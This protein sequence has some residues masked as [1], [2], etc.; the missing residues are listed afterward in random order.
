MASSPEVEYVHCF[1]A[2]MLWLCRTWDQGAGGGTGGQ[3]W[4][5]ESLG[6]GP[7]AASKLS[8]GHSG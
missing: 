7:K 6:S 5:P 3:V 2:N 4:L 8:Y 1:R